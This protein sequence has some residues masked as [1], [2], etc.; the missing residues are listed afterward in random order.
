[1]NETTFEIAGPNRWEVLNIWEWN[2]AH[3]IGELRIMMFSGQIHR[4]IMNNLNFETKT[5]THW[6]NNFMYKYAFCRAVSYRLH[7]RCLC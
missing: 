4:Y 7:F 1:M 2:Y 5:E 6:L 3:I